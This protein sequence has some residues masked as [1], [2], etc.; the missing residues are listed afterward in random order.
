[1]Y[2]CLKEEGRS[3]KGSTLTGTIHVATIHFCLPHSV[4]STGGSLNFHSLFG[5]NALNYSQIGLLEEPKTLL[6]IS[7]P[8]EAEGNKQFMKSLVCERA[9]R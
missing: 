1:M 8:S 5:R 6:E 4:A 9:L 3:Y 2:A 7:G